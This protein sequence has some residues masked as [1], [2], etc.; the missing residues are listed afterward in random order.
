MKA[1][2]VYPRGFF[3]FDIG[4]PVQRENTDIKKLMNSIR[5][6]K[7]NVSRDRTVISNDEIETLY[8]KALNNEAGVR[9]PE[10]RERVLKA[11][12]SAF[13][14]KSFYEW[15]ELQ[16]ESPYF[17]AMHRRFLND[18]FEF[19]QTGER[20]VNISNWDKLV[21]VNQAD[22]TDTRVSFDYKK[23][24]KMDQVALF[25][26]PFTVSGTVQSWVSQ[27][28]GFEDLIRSLRIIFCDSPLH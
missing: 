17:T 15:C 19:I 21:R 22:I 4:L 14:T 8:N 1:V 10:H 7:V 26:R 11:A 23:Y 24:F 28:G 2:V 3:G 12:L 5:F 9:T 6:N 18:T 20:S 27:P 13:G 16:Q 25:R